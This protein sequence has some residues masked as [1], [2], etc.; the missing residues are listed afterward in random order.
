MRSTARDATEPRTGPPT[1][2]DERAGTRGHPVPARRRS[3]LR[4]APDLRP[5]ERERVELAVHHALLERD[6]SVV[7]EVDVL[8]AHLAAALGDVA[9]AEPELVLR[10]VLAVGHVE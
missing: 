7:G 10:R 1:P 2:S 4:S 8:R 3:V 6:D 9:V 5:E